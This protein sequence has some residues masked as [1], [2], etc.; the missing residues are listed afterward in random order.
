MLPHQPAG[1][2]LGAG[3]AGVVFLYTGDYDCHAVYMLLLWYMLSTNQAAAFQR[4]QPRKF[5]NAENRQNSADFMFR[6]PTKIGRR[7]P[8]FLV[9]V[10]SALG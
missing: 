8:I 9:S 1:C 4:C 7:R 2:N 10:T 6:R 3:V 5:D